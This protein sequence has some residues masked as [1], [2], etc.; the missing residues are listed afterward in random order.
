[1][2]SK[3]L[4]PQVNSCALLGLGG[5]LWGVGVGLCFVG[6]GLGVGLG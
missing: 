6:L 3:N 5:V 2:L 4:L 1:M